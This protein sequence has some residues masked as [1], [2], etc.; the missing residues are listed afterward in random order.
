MTIELCDGTRRM[1][2]RRGTDSSCSVGSTVPRAAAWST[3]ESMSCPS[4]PVRRWSRR[5]RVRV[6]LDRAPRC[7]R[8]HPWRQVKL[9]PRAGRGRREPAG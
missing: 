9:A 5:M 7:P 3:T 2:A 1:S 8:T 4:K 6:S